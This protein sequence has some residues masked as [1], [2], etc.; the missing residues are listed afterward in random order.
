MARLDER[1]EHLQ[2]IEGDYASLKEYLGRFL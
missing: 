1:E 2:R